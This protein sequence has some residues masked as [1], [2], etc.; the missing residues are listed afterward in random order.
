MGRQRA[1]KAM[2]PIWTN[3]D[4]SRFY[5][6]D[7]EGTTETLATT[8]AMR[9]FMRRIG[10]RGGH[11]RSRNFARRNVRCR[12]R[13]WHLHRCNPNETKAAPVCAS[14]EEWHCLR[15]FASRGGKARARKYP[16]EQLRA[17]AAKGGHAKAAK[18]KRVSLPPQGIA[19]KQSD[20]PGL[21]IALRKRRIH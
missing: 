15:E 8:D 6:P 16:R 7:Y 20:E 19:G 11:E 18:S 2:S 1:G 12:A 10:R 5:V 3:P 4:G 17:W 9:Q 14:I 13:F 21:G